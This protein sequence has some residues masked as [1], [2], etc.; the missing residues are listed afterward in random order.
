MSRFLQLRGPVQK[1]LIDLGQASMISDGDFCFIKEMVS[2]LEPLKLAVAA[3]CR[4]DTNLLSGEAALQFCLVELQKQN[5]E[6]AR[7]LADVLGSRIQQRRKV[8]A[9]VLQYLHS[10]T[11]RQTATEVFTI[12]SNDTIRKFICR[13]T[14]RLESTPS[15]TTS[16]D[17]S[18]SSTNPTSSQSEQDS[19]E[20]ANEPSM[21]QK[22]EMAMRQSVAARTPCHSN[23]SQDIDKKLDASIKAEMAV[24]TSSGRRGRCLEQSYQ[25]LLCIPPTSV[26]AERAFSAAG[27]MCTKLRSRLDDRSLD[28]L[29]FL[30]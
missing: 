19:E 29:C 25:Y 5:S 2:C 27:V 6:L 12:S 9:A 8:H 26:E 11:A 17:T 18:D 15:A 3:L 4:R 21:Q 22:M 1:A 23:S 28:T 20:T 10:N 7:T 13:L 30:L 14:A 24:F 16:A